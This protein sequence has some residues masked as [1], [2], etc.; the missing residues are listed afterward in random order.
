MVAGLAMA[1][2]ECFHVPYDIGWAGIC[3]ALIGKH[4]LNRGMV[5]QINEAVEHQ[6][7]REIEA[8]ELGRLHRIK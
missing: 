1:V 5:C 4:L 8:F 6:A 2:V 3:V 7:D